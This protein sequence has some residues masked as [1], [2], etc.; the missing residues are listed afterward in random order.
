[1]HPFV[2][3]QLMIG[4][5]MAA[6]SFLGIVL[7]VRGY[8]RALTIPFAV[9]CISASIECLAAPWRYLSTTPEAAVAGLRLSVSTFLTL[10]LLWFARAYSEWPNKWVPTAMT[11]ALLG[12]LG[13]NLTLPYTIIFESVSGVREI[14]LPWGETIM[15]L[16]GTQNRYLIVAHLINFSFILFLIA[17]GVRIWRFGNRERAW[18]YTIAIG[19]FVFLAYPHGLLVNRGILP[20]P[21]FH[22]ISILSAVLILWLFLTNEALRAESLALEVISNERRWRSLLDGVA[23]LVVGCDRSGILTYINPFLSKTTGYASGE[24]LGKTIETI[25]A[26]K[27]FA[28]A[29]HQAIGGESLEF[30][31]SEV[32]TKGGSLRSIVWS[33]VVLRGPNNLATGMLSVG[34]DVTERLDAE[35]ARNAAMKQLEELKSRLEA[36]NTVLKIEIEESSRLRS[37]NIIGESD[38]VRYVLHKI[39][40]VA[41]TDATVLIEGETGVGK[42]L[43]ARA[44]HEKSARS[45]MPFVRVNCAALPASLVESELFG[46]EK[47]SFTGAERLRKGRFEVAEGGTLFLDEVGELPLELQGKLLRVLQE[48][49][50]ERV[51]SS[52]TRKANVRIIAATNRPLL[53]DV[54]ARRLREDLFYRLH[55]YPI[56]VPPLRERRN[57]IP[58]LVQHFVKELSVRYKKTI[59]EVPVHLMQRLINEDWPG[60]VRELR[61]VVERAVIVTTGRLLA[62]PSDSSAA[63]AHSVVATH[64][65]LSTLVELERSH[66]VRVLEATKGQIAGDGGAAEILGLHPSTLRSRMI[67]LGIRREENLIKH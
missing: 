44:V 22:S 66:I 55:V 21:S 57:D 10:G 60:N 6:V 34:S 45:G 32:K 4:A 41:A 62:W 43:V 46:H 54:A 37:A 1:M 28:N 27:K 25:D 51:G 3:G 20:P 2:T 26:G 39:Q 11:V 58:L 47:G 31:E 65:S 49:E 18:V 29:F 53:R 48:G 16:V 19:P 67:K 17:S 42:E 36:E 8:K 23:L 13:L 15:T 5:V 50:F 63:P 61:N 40:Q 59:D 24:L 56:T 52:E 33:N 64:A 14:R 38:S 30:F 7:S 12:V 9:T 35:H